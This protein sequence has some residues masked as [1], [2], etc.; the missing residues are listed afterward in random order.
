MAEESATLG[1]AEKS[2]TPSAARRKTEAEPEAPQLKTKRLKEYSIQSHSGAPPNHTYADVERFARALEDIAA[3][4][5]GVAGVQARREAL[6]G[7]VDALLSAYGRRE[8]WF[9]EGSE[10]VRQELSHARY[11][12]RKAEATR[13]GLHQ[14][15]RLTDASLSSVGQRYLQR[16][17]HLS[18]LRKE[19]TSE[20]SWL[21]E[22][23]SGLHSDGGDGRAPFDSVVSEALKALLSQACGAELCSEVGPEAEPELTETE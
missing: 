9:R 5:A 22:V 7:D 2:A 21:Q 16:Q 4:Q 15:L 20:L 13:R 23:M 1:V 17:A 19:L 10:G 3:M 8:A 14:D 6:Q 18:T 12:L 11:E